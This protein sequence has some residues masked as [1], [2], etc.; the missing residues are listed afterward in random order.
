MSISETDDVDYLS[1]LDTAIDKCR[2]YVDY[3]D[4]FCRM[5]RFG[6]ESGCRAAEARAIE[7]ERRLGVAKSA[8]EWYA[9]GMPWND[10]FGNE[11][12]CALQALKEIGEDK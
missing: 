9:N 1:D 4:A 12:E 6:Y 3:D 2:P 10:K 7:A 5:F 8:L 11:T